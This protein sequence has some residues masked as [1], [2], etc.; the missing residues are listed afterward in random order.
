MSDV[1]MTESSFEVFVGRNTITLASIMTRDI[2]A[3]DHTKT[4][5]DAATLME[6]KGIGSIVINA[7]ERP[8]GIVTERDL[9][10][11]MAT[12]SISAESHPEFSGIKT[13]DLCMPHPIHPRSL[14]TNGKI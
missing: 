8:F 11:I 10:R 12:L 7:Y 5:Y 3:M 1:I 4:A 14:R 2:I 13:I 9:R 6:E